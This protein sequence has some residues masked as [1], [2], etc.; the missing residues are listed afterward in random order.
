MAATIRRQFFRLPYQVGVAVTRHA[1]VPCANRRSNAS[2]KQMSL[3]GQQGTSS[4]TRL[5]DGPSPARFRGAT[6]RSRPCHG[7]GPNG[8]GV[9]HHG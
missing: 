8:C 5:I 6:P 2:P 3:L 9:S 1:A 7:T 4:L